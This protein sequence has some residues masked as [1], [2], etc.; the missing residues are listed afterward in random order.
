MAD[1]KSKTVTKTI[2]RRKRAIASVRLF[3]GTGDIT[4]NE[5]PI[6]QYFPGLWAK[7]VYDKPFKV[8]GVDK[9]DATIKVHGGGPAGQLD[10]ATLGI[11]RALS[12]LKADFH[13]QLR[14]ADLLTRDPR[15]RERRMI[16]TGGKSRRTKQSPKR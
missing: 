11:A 13:T 10:A 14:Q 3:A 16:G 4:V 8:V 9:F 7:L 1:P 6:S 12:E 15:K 2:G 5:K